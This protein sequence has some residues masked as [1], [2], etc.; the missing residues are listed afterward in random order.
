MTAET[1]QRVVRDVS[2]LDEFRHDLAGEDPVKNRILTEIEKQYVRG[3]AD[4]HRN[5]IDPRFG[6]F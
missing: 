1:M 5:S 2:D 3:M 6:A 4:V